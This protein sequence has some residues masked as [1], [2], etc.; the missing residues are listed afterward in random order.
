M[1]SAYK[2]VYLYV[3]NELPAII[4][5][6]MIPKMKLNL[7][8]SSLLLLFSCNSTNNSKNTDNTVPN[9]EKTIM[10][11]FAH[12]DDETIVSPLLSKY[13]KEGVN[14]HLV[15]VTDGSK[16]VTKHA[17]IPAGDSLAKVRA[18]EALC[19]ARTLG[20]NP[21]I[22]LN[23][24]DGNLGLLNNIFSLHDKIDSLLTK[25]QPD[26]VITF[27]PDGAYGHSDHRIVSNVVTEIFQKDRPVPL[28]QLLYV[29]FLKETF[30]SAPK[31]NTGLA[32]WFKE[33]MNTTQKKFLTYRIPFDKDDFKVAREAFGCCK[34]QYSPEIMDELF[35][36]THHTGILYLRPWNGSDIIKSDIFE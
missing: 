35:I 3:Y 15:L 7:I 9:N 1:Y 27:G 31:L 32:N 34:S 5:F 28:Q 19:T 20:I 24:E 17:N 30:D 21:T 11:I 18:E 26:V 2:R 23:F 8:I 25:Y 10:A 29:G 22:L 13:A 14:I 12:S 16:G 6:I 36:L 33:S 4:K